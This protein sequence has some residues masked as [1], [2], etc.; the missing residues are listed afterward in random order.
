MFALAVGVF[1]LYLAAPAQSVPPNLKLG[2][3]P[4]V[5]L[6]EGNLLIAI[7]LE[8]TGQ[9]SADDVMLEDISLRQ[10]ALVKP[11][12][13]P[14]P[15]GNIAP[16]QDVLLQ[17]AFN[18]AGIRPGQP[19]LLSIRGTYLYKSNN[20]RQRFQVTRIINGPDASE[21]S[22]QPT[23]ERALPP[24]TTNGAIYPPDDRGFRPDQ[25]NEEEPS[26]PLPE[27]PLR[28]NLQPDGPELRS[29]M[30]PPGQSR[31]KEA[32]AAN[33]PVTFFRIGTQNVQNNITSLFP[34]DPS[35]ASADVASGQLVFLT[36]NTYALLS[37]NGGTS[38][39]RIDPTTI[40]PNGADGGLCCDQ[41]IQYVPS[42]NRIIWFMQ[43]R[44]G[45]GSNSNR[46]RIASAS[47]QQ[48]VSSG[49]T[50]WTYW[51][52]TSATFNLGN[53]WMD[54]PDMAFTNDF[55][56]ISTDRVSLGLFVIR[57]PLTEIRDSVTIHLRYTDPAN[58]GTAYGSHLTQDLTN[59]MYWF[60]QVSTSSMRVFRWDDSSTGYS[61]RTIAV[62][63][64]NNSNYATLAPNGVDW[65]NFSFGRTAVRGATHERD[66]PLFGTAAPLLRVAWSAGRGGGFAQPY[67]R[68][69]EFADIN[70]AF[71]T[72][73]VKVS[74]SQIWN[75]GFAFQHPYLST[76]SD[77]EVGIS[78][79]VGGPSNHATPI[80]GF[81]GDSTLYFA[82]T[83]STTISRWGDYSAI[84][85][86]PNNP[87]LF[88]VSNYFLQSQGVSGVTGGRVVHQ[89]IM[90][91]RTPNVIN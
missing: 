52:M 38:F 70:S 42:I 84:R 83:S 41:V 58:G 62:N 4:G 64:W 34:W 26:F 86:H 76:N 78:L 55:L 80:V 57:I 22:D 68:M 73:L 82:N 23:I 10:Q 91:G 2:E 5:A 16:D 60:G 28:G 59:R 18:G 24:L 32:L 3:L 6:E 56:F 30:P 79:G 13:L 77:G 75:S 29:I 48:V 49:A 1:A 35:G 43:F 9:T 69:V 44:R 46:I 31:S 36:G 15:V 65:L 19:Y 88:S 61:W 37:T 72:A 54:Y 39:T 11:A 50:A 63:S 53:N 12:S 7:Q 89:Y 90:F 45:A 27:G 20:S 47:P 14:L 8:N 67:V 74:E 40:F 33:D 81:V 71:L 21:A 87:K 25:A 85:K 66:I 17:L 51:D